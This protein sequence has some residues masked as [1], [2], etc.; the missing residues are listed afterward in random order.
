M[1]PIKKRV[2][3][4]G[5]RVT[6]KS[7]RVVINTFVPHADSAKGQRFSIQTGIEKSRRPGYV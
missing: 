6:E 1:E 2:S 5:K 4:V 3:Q 7:I